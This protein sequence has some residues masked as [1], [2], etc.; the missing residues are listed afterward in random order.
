MISMSTR[1]SSDRYIP[2]R[3][4]PEF[5]K[6][7]ED[8]LSRRVGQP[9]TMMLGD[10]IVAVGAQR[11]LFTGES[12]V[13]MDAS[14]LLPRKRAAEW[15]DA[16]ERK[17]NRL[18]KRVKDVEQLYAEIQRS[19]APEKTGAIVLEHVSDY[20]DDFF[21]AL[22]SVIAHD[23]GRL[24]LSHARDFEALREYLRMVRRRARNGQAAAMWRELAHGAA[25]QRDLG[26][27]PGKSPARACSGPWLAIVGWFRARPR[28]QAAGD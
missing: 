9:V 14:P 22:A 20:D 12:V 28:V 6:K 7:V 2:P 3:I 4:A 23:K 11:E 18:S 10:G 21:E 13:V 24:D 15:A 17:I 19:P 5:I 16:F 8:E 26:S 27:Q 1:L 25:Q